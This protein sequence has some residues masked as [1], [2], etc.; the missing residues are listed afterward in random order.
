MAATY[1]VVA[2][3]ALWI[4]L[5]TTV[6]VFNAAL[7]QDFRHPVALI[8][9]HML[10]GSCLIFC[11]RLVKPGWVYTGDDEKGIPPLTQWT[12]FR[13]GL[14]VALVHCISMVF[15]NT[16]YLHLKVG[17]IQMIKAWT[18]GLVYLVG[19]GMGTQ[20]YST[21]VA[22]TILGITLGLTVASLGELEFNWTG[23]SLQVVSILLEG[24]RI[25]LLE[26]YLKSKGYKLNPLSSLQIFAPI[27]LVCLIPLVLVLDMEA[28]QLE[29]LEQVGQL[30]LVVNALCA[31]FLNLSVYLVI[32]VASGLMFALGGVFKDVLIICGSVIVF[33]SPLTVT[34]IIGYLFAL[35]SL[36]AYGQVSKE[37]AAYEDGVIPVLWK[38]LLDWQRSVHARVPTIEEGDGKTSPS[39]GESAIHADTLGAEEGDAASG[40]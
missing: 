13:L 21:P 37:P 31:F 1:V 3:I 14:P 10:V 29:K 11:V 32:Q 20:T 24:V 5:S 34:Q 33:G 17:F 22:K 7:L 23:F 36:Q 9:W 8:A 16:A 38:R 39:K 27:M 25:N 40:K 28:L 2:A 15:G 4:S 12:A 26:I 18:S 35:A 30:T 19:C 6:I